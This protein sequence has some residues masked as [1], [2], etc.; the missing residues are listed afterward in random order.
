MSATILL[1][2][3]GTA[4]GLSCIPD[5]DALT[6]HEMIDQGS[7]GKGQYPVMILGVVR[8]LKDV[9]GDPDGGRTVARI[10][11]VEHR[12]RSDTPRMSRVFDSGASFPTRGRSASC[13]S[14]WEAGTS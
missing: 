1:L 5:E 8:S 2:G 4:T 11:V 14:R 7:T 13:S 6:F 3:P 9:G 12:T 10:E